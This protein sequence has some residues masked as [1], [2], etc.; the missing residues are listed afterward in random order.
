[1]QIGELKPQSASPFISPI[2]AAILEAESRTTGEIHVHLSRRWY[3]KDP[4]ARAN[5]L[6]QRFDMAQTPQ[7]NA[8]LLYVNLRKRRLAL[9]GDKGIQAR[10]SARFWKEQAREL[11]QD[12]RATQFENA[13]SA[14]V[15]RLGHELERRFPSPSRP[16]E[17]VK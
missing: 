17:K 16:N 2:V 7:R 15:R 10:V 12:L 5:R 11:S 4:L 1:V 3:E 13:I 14:A 9:V 6:F 8:V